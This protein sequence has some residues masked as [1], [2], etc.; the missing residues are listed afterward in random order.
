MPIHQVT[1]RSG[2]KYARKKSSS[3]ANPSRTSTR[4]KPPHTKRTKLDE[5]MSETARTKKKGPLF[6]YRK[7]IAADS[8]TKRL[9]YFIDGAKLFR[10]LCA[11]EPQ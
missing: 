10:R 1:E 8:D 7:T 2:V 11:Q 6:A 9:T 4:N 5:E 3:K